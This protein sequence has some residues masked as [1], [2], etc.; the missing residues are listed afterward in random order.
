MARNL[1][2]GALLVAVPGA[3]DLILGTATFLSPS[4]FQV[5]R[6]MAGVGAKGLAAWELA[7]QF[8]M[9]WHIT[10]G[11]LWIIV[12]LT[13]FRKGE[14]WAWYAIAVAG[15]VLFGGVVYIHTSAS[16]TPEFAPFAGTG[17][18]IL[19]VATIAAPWLVGLLLAIK[20]VFKR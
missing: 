16:A 17:E 12:S 14:R 3:L 11:I 9:I 8:L 1:T 6:A 10:L 19:Q 2:I 4:L 5:P 7:I 18:N 13:A 15:S 20:Q